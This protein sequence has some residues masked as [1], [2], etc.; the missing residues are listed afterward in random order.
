MLKQDEQGARPRGP[1]AIGGER[2]VRQ[3]AVAGIA[4]IE[5]V[6][7]A[8]EAE[9]KARSRIG[10]LRL[11]YEKRDDRFEWRW[12][13]S[14]KRSR[15]VGTCVDQERLSMLRPLAQAKVRSVQRLLEVRA[16]ARA[17]LRLVEWAVMSGDKWGEQ[18]VTLRWSSGD[19]RRTIWLFLL[20]GGIVRRGAVQPLDGVESGYAAVVGRLNMG[21]QPQGW[22]GELTEG[23]KCVVDEIQRIDERLLELQRRLQGSVR[24]YYG[25]QRDTW[26]VRQIF[27][28]Q[29]SRHV[30]NKAGR[31]LI[32][33]VKEGERDG[34]ERVLEGIERR[35][36]LKRVLHL[37]GVVGEAMQHWPGGQWQLR[38]ETGDGRAAVWVATATDRGRSVIKDGAA[39]GQGEMV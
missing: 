19:L 10:R 11:Y 29:R 7:Q 6:L 37:I 4:V 23:V 28:P 14:A 34:L 2:D 22:R 24:V 15:R 21:S 12:W 20:S 9:L 26:M 31:G 30:S 27:G 8:V 38:G 5:R 25:K 33:K 18:T 17:V 13:E 3:R 35:K 39:V 32:E 16:S 36:R 1:Y